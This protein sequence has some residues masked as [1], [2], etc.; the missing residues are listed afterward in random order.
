LRRTPVQ[1]SRCEAMLMKAGSFTEHFVK[2][3]DRKLSDSRIDK[4]F[5]V[6]YSSEVFYLLLM[7]MKQKPFDQ[8]LKLLQND[9]FA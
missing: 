6:S 4:N 7:G 2:K 1:V 8:I 9:R 5:R 3:A